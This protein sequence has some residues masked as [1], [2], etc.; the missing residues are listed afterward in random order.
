MS[1]LWLQRGCGASVRT[2]GGS[3]GS[4]IHQGTAQP[5]SAAEKLI[6]ERAAVRKDVRAATLRTH[7]EKDGAPDVE[8]THAGAGKSMRKKR[9]ESY[10]VRAIGTQFTTC[11]KHE[12]LVK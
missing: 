9:T 10:K 5:F 2:G 11:L 7:M 3:P 6:S 12:H 8:R 1:K 4:R